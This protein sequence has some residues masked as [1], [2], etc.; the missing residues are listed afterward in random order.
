M[1]FPADVRGMTSEVARRAAYPTGAHH[2]RC[3][4]CG[5]LV[6]RAAF[7]CRRCGKRQRV[8]PRWIMLGLGTCLMAAMFAVATV[9]ALSS[10]AH[11]VEAASQPAS[12]VTPENQV[13]IAPGRSGRSPDQ[14]ARAVTLTAA[15]LWME[16][17]RDPAGA[18]REFRGRPVV[19]S[20]TV[21]SIERDFDGRLVVRLSTGGGLD[22]VNAKLAVREDSAVSLV[23]KG[24]PLSLGC[25]GRGALI[26]VPLLGNCSVL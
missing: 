21:R 10:P 1:A 23:G 13:G 6:A 22:T 8:R 15:D 25:V 12:G 24:R 5:K 16:Y 11:S 20:G 2:K 26:G 3:A 9:S 19:V 14:A 18:D 7:Q 4:K 17:A